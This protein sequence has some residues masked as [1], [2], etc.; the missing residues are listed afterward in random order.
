MRKIKP[1]ANMIFERAIIIGKKQITD[2]WN[3]ANNIKS[4]NFL[5]KNPTLDFFSYFECT[6]NIF[7]NS[8]VSH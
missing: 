3:K 5:K 1:I 6:N 8:K 4:N 7:S 2:T